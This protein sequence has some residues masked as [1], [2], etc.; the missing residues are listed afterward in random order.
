MTTATALLTCL[1]SLAA[2]PATPA[3]AAAQATAAPPG[4]HPAAALAPPLQLPPA[5]KTGGLP[6]LDALSR[7]STARAFEPGAL[8]PQQ[9]SDLLWA[10]WGVN[11][12]DGKRTAPSSRDRKELEV[13]VL[14]PGGAYLFDPPAQAL[15]PLVAE[16]LRAVGTS[17]EFVKD[18]ALTLAYVA[19]LSRMGEGTDAEKAVTAAF[20]TGF[21]SQ[22]VYLWCASEGLA[23]GVRSWIDREALGR[24]LGLSPTQRIT[25][26]QSIGRAKT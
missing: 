26:V 8:A 17:Q 3:T 16:D 4:P 2:P 12:P 5:R 19:D 9:L 23:T 1:L 25:A 10:A 15:R 6:L 11:R 24:R 14:L 7:R 18:A 20:D 22:N 21:V 13:Y